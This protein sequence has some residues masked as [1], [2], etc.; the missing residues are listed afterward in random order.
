MAFFEHCT[1]SLHQ[2]IEISSVGNWVI[3]DSRKW[4]VNKLK[5]SELSIWK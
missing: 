1:C 3:Y 2:A 5:V 4:N